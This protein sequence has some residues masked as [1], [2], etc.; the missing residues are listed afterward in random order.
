MIRIGNVTIESQVYQSSDRISYNFT[1]DKSNQR[2]VESGFAMATS[3]EFDFGDVDVTLY[4]PK[5][6][7]E[8]IRGEELTVIFT[9][10]PLP[11]SETDELIN[12]VEVLESSSAD[13]GETILAYG[14]AIAELAEMIAEMGEIDG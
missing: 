14:D 9:A 2:N 12:K 1:C 4:A 11:T 7:I 10:A 3:V 6:E 13:M 8:Q 5:L